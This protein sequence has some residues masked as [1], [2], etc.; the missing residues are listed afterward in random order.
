VAEDIDSLAVED[1]PERR[2]FEARLDGGLAGF[3]TYHQ[4]PDRIV[5]IHT[6]VDDA[7]RGLGIGTRLARHVLDEVRRRGMRMTPACPF[8]REFLER[9]PSY[10]DLVAE[11]RPPSS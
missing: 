2:R 9:E 3:M 7:Y 6:E 11:P 1:V 10:R 5:L 4:R 8:V